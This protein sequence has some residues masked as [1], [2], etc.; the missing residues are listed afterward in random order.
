MKS[1]KI[2]HFNVSDCVLWTVNQNLNILHFVLLTY[3]YLLYTTG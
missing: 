2:Y 1:S 3:C